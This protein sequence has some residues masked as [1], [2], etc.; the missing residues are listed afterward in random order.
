MSAATVLA[1]E[2]EPVR[3]G[4]LGIGSPRLPTRLGPYDDADPFERRLARRHRQRLSLPLGDPEREE[5]EETDDEE[6]NPL[7]VRDLLCGGCHEP[8]GCCLCLPEK[9]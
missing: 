6:T 3:P 8:I 9:N 4:L 2:L 1:P 7:F 5:T